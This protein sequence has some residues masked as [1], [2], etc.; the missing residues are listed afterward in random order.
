MGGEVYLQSMRHDFLR[1]SEEHLSIR[2]VKNVYCEEAGLAKNSPSPLKSQTL[3]E[4][5][6]QATLRQ[7]KQ[8]LLQWVSTSVMS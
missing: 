3:H 8:A 5:K 2:A 6:H 7:P 1:N 4:E